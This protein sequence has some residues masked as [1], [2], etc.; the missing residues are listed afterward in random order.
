MKCTVNESP[1]GQKQMKAIWV[2]ESGILKI[3]IRSEASAV[4][5]KPNLFQYLQ[6]EQIGEK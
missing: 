1:F 5:F 6:V 3:C 2:K 4:I